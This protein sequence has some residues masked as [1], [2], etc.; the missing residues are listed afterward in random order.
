MPGDVDRGV[1]EMLLEVCHRLLVAVHQ[2]CQRQQ[3]GVSDD[4]DR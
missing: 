2:R 4:D 1:S 3:I